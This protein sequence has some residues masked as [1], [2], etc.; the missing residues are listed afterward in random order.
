MR[1]VVTDT[2][3]I[4]SYLSGDSLDS[5]ADDVREGLSRSFKELAP[6]YFYD[7]RGSEL[8]DRITS[9]PEY[10]PTRCERE[11]LNRWAPQIVALSEAEELVELGSGTASKT[12]ALLYAMAGTGRLRRYVPMDCS[13]SVVIECADELSE[14]YPGL[15]VHGVVGDFERHL[16]HL[17]DGESRLFAFLGGTIGNFYP[18]ARSRFLAYL[19]TLMGPTDHVLLGTDLVKDVDVLEAA[20]ND[21]EGVTAD[22]NRNVLRVI[23]QELGADFD[24]DAFEHVA[25]F[26]PD[27]CWIEMRLRSLVDQDVHVDG[28]TIHFGEGEEIRTEISAKFTREQLGE[29]FDEAGLALEAFFTDPDGHFAL[30]LASVK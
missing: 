14:I 4:D 29:E 26:D 16:E 3:R 5:I 23:N 19:R 24:L 11:I 15:E 21:S 18:E 1:S 30:T 8:F 13:E 20:Y 17:P 7:A 27:S 22:F 28:T 10:Y 25:F 6:K 9:L 12:R 2:I